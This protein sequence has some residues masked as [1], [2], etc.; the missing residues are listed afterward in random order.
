MTQQAVKST[1]V[2]LQVP[3]FESPFFERE[4]DQSELDGETKEKVAF[5]A[6]NGY[7]VIEPDIPDFDRMADEITG[8]L[9]D[10]HAGVSNRVQDAWRYVPAVRDLATRPEVLR[11]LELL[12][13]R[14]AV[15]FQTLN[16]RRGTQ[17]RTHS[18]HV[19]FNSLP[20]RFMAGVWFALEDVGPD[21]GALHYYPGSH[22]LS[23]YEP[24]DLGLSGSSVRSR[25][26]DYRQ[27]EAFL[28]QLIDVLGLQ[29]E[30][31]RMSRGQAIIWSANL[32]HGGDPIQDPQSTRR[33]QV[34]HYYF[35]GCRYYTPLY[36]DPP[37]GRYDWT[38]V[39]DITTGREQP[40]MY[41]GKKV[42]LPAKN[43][44]RYAVEQRLKESETGRRV[45]RAAKQAL[46]SR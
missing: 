14:R 3:W 18:D 46:T 22:R 12:Y 15:P 29:K 16:F 21:N 40:H 17:Q 2:R 41:N 19:H 24:H 6:E 11:W 35:E 1:N 30:T 32:L 36:S 23:L 28:D 10:E 38:R 37:L 45:F 5:F 13:G 34:T 42:R 33:S 39:I 8:A 43:R 7:L 9:A 44:A 26:E 4:L 25:N 31:V 27:Y 20:L